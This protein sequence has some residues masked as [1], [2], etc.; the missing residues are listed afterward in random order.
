[1]NKPIPEDLNYTWRTACAYGKTGNDHVI[2]GEL[3]VE[4]IERIGR[5]EAENIRMRE[6]HLLREKRIAD[7]ET[8]REEIASLKRGIAAEREKRAAL[9]DS[10]SACQV[11]VHELEKKEGHK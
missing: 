10:L 1:M 11:R 8:G 4:L 5:L 2:C 6:N 9:R 3:V 7:L